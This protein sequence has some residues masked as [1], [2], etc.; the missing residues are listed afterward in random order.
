MCV[1]QGRKARELCVSGQQGQ[2]SRHPCQVTPFQPWYLRQEQRQPP[3]S[4]S[5]TSMLMMHIKTEAQTSSRRGVI[6]PWKK[7]IKVIVNAFDMCGMEFIRT[8][9]YSSSSSCGLYHLY[10][11]LSSF[12]VRSTSSRL[13]STFRLIWK[14]LAIR[15]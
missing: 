5:S 1:A 3:A 7:D 4:S 10:H 6:A 8:S 9:S 15:H 14:F 11:W 2:S 13:R 12:Q